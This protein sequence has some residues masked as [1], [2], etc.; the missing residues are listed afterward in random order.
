V[1]AGEGRTFP[2][3]LTYANGN[4][5]LELLLDNGPLDTA[6]HP[7]F[8]AKGPDGRACVTCH[9]PA[10]GMSLAVEDVRRQWEQHGSKDPLFAAIDGSNCPSLPQDQRQSHSLLLDHGLIRIGRHWPP[11]DSKGSVIA[12]DFRIEV[13]RDPTGC[14]LDPAWGMTSPRSQ[15]SVFR[16]PRSVANF[17]F[18][19]AMG[20]AYDPRRACRC[21]STRKAASRS[22]VI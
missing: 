4:G 19:E 14:N 9:Q 16:R 11:L 21:R 5:T 13:L 1:A 17:K 20:F 3:R 15:I 2:A 8:S 18:I 6:R 22:A 7:F 10:D 12:P